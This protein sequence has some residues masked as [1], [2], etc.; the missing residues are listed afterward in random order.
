MLYR[1][2]D[3]YKLSSDNP[4]SILTFNCA[5]NMIMETCRA[6]AEWVHKHGW[7]NNSRPCFLG[8]CCLY[9]AAVHLDGLDGLS[10]D[11]AWT[12]RNSL[13]GFSA[14]W[15]LGGMYYLCGLN[16]IKHKGKYSDAEQT[17]FCTISTLEGGYVPPSIILAVCPRAKFLLSFELLID[18]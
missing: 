8:L 11:D 5:H 14:R 15:K 12:L 2:N 7:L 16:A 13:M 3:Y 4:K 17:V 6:E 18:S 9:G 1:T 10:A